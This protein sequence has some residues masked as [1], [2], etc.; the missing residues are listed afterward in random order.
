MY[1]D[2][3]QSLA[4][5]RDRHQ[6]SD[7]TP[8]FGPI[9]DD[10]GLPDEWRTH[11]DNALATRQW[12]IERCPAR[13]GP[14]TA[15]S[16]PDAH[17][18]LCDLEELFAQ[19][20]ADQRK[21]VDD[22]IASPDI[23]IADKIDALQLA[24]AQQAER[25]DWILEHWPNIIEHHELT[26]IVDAAGPLGHRP[27][28]LPE[29]AQ[30]LLDE[31]R[32]TSVDTPEERTLLELDRAVAAHNPIHQ[33]RRLEHDL[34]PL[35]RQIRQFDTLPTDDANRNEMTRTHVERLRERAR[36]IEADIARAEV[37]ATLHKWTHRTE[38]ELAAAI[39]RRTNHLAHVALNSGDPAIAE[40]AASLT[41]EDLEAT[42]N[43][44]RAAIAHDVAGRE[45][46]VSE[47]K[48]AV[49]IERDCQ[50]SG[51]TDLAHCC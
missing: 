13:P 36:D 22:L 26:A 1:D 41:S 51:V 7:N 4:T 14:P 46:G 45:R 38:P 29:R 33:I 10:C 39:N 31:V 43:D 44:L 32:R 18:R 3:L 21:I 30:A 20:P 15:I 5:W 48:T 50:T 25:R 27:Q 42:A 8:G 35:R 23:N 9:P 47:P 24:G 40:L 19:A 16:I 2:H 11:M 37:Q 12:L 49:E 28:A 6:L 34:K 17:H